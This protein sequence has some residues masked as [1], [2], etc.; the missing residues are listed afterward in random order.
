MKKLTGLFLVFAVLILPFTAFAGFT[1]TLPQGTFLLDE[2][3]IMSKLNSMW[4]DEG[5]RVPLIDPIERYEPG[6]GLQGILKPEPVAEFGIIVTQLQ[7]GILDNLT[8]GIG[9]PIVLYTDVDPNLKW[10]PGD[11]QWVLGRPYSAKDF[12][13]WAES[14]GQPKPGKW[15]GNKGVLADI[16]LGLRYRFTD[17]II[18][19]S[20]IDAAMAVQLLG[21]LPTGK[22][23][24]MEEVVS[25]GTTSWELHSNGELGFHL[26]FDK[27]FKEELDGRLTLGLDAFYEI[28]FPHQYLSP[29]GKKNPLL[30]NFRPYTGKYFTIDGGDFSGAS[31]QVDIVPYRGPALS[32]WLTKKDPSQGEKLPPILGLTFRY[33]F[34][35]LQ[36]SDWDSNS[37][38]WDYE[39]EKLWRPGYKNILF[40][41]ATISL[42]RVGVPF[43][44]YVAYRN[45]TWIPGKNSR[46][47]DVLMVGTRIIAKFW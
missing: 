31:F 44:P 45:L 4:N 30:Q 40:G 42:L 7:Y 18:P 27:F 20:K 14:M 41:Q 5:K 47:V 19:F 17:R 16:I 28:H 38:I 24:D 2:F 37:E 11:H 26:S 32:T 10:E 8:L 13:Q 23:A 29:T 1:E 21:A 15:S 36:Q 43:M 35:H 34:T 9:I 25:A 22:P 33:T 12:W 46:A 39:K 6:S 3:F